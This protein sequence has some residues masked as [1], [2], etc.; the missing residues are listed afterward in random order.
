[1]TNEKGSLSLAVS[2]RM[3]PETE[4]Y[5]AEGEVN[6][7]QLNREKIEAKNCLEKIC[8]AMRN[9]LQDTQFPNYEQDKADKLEQA[10][11]HTLNWIYQNQHAEKDEFE[12]K[13]QELTGVGYREGMSE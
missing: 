4:K 12:A 7:E 3:V 1:V 8:V 5:S 10:V 9:T 2:G 13:V 11:W 6:L